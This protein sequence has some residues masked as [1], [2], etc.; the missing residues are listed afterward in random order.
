MLSVEL[1]VKCYIYREIIRIIV[2]VGFSR[3]Q[4]SDLPYLNAHCIHR[5]I[6]NSKKI[7]YNMKK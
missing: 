3:P 5:Y 7:L 4:I 1:S 2:G 6:E